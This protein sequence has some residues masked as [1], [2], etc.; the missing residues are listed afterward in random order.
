MNSNKR[1]G[2][3]FK[4]DKLTKGE[5]SCFPISV[6]QQLNREEVYERITREDLRHLARTMDHHMLRLNV[7]DF[8]CRLNWNHEKVLELKEIFN[9]DQAAKAE[10]GEQ[11]ETWEVYWQKM[12]KHTEWADG[13]FIRATAWYLQMV[14]QIMDTKCK[15]DEP[16]YRIDGDFDDC[17]TD[18]L[19]IGYVSEVH[20]QS[21]LLDD[22]SDED[23]DIEESGRVVDDDV[24]NGQ[25]ISLE[26]D[27][28][29]DRL[30]TDGAVIDDESSDLPSLEYQEEEKNDV[31]DS[32]SSKQED[33]E[34]C[35]SCRKNF[36]HVLKHIKKSKK[37]KV[38]DADIRRLEERSKMIR[39]EKV[40]HW[41]SDSR[42]RLRDEDYQRETKKIRDSTAKSRQK[43]K[44]ADPEAYKA[45][46][47]KDNESKKL[48]QD[49]TEV[50]RLRR[51]QESVM[52]G[53]LFVCVSCHGK[54]FRCSVKILTNRLVQQ[55]DDRIPIQDCIDFD[56]V[57]KVVTESRHVSL[58]PMFK[59]S[60][61][62]V[63][64]R[65]ICETCLRYLKKGEL[66]PKS[67]KNS[68]ELHYT[69]AGL[70]KEDLCL[71]ELEGSLIAQNIVFQKIYQLPKSR[72]T[73]L[74]DKIVNV[75]ISPE[76]INNTLALLPRTPAQAGLIGIS[77]KRK[78]E[79]KNTHK[80]QLI[81]PDK[82]FRMLQKLKESGSPYHQNLLTPANYRLMC[83]ETDK[84]G[85]ET[86]Y[87]EE[88]DILEELEG[89]P[90]FDLEDEITDEETQE[91]EDS[92]DEESK[93]EK[94]K[95]LDEDEEMTKKDPVRKYHF[96]YDESLCMMDKFPEISVAPGEGQRPKG[97]LG[98]KHWDVKAF[99]HLHNLDGS[100]GKD[101]D[102]KVKL[103]EQDYFIQRI[104]N[105]EKRFAETPAYLYSSVAYLEE[106]RIQQSL[107]LVGS[108]G[109][110]VTGE[111]GSVSYQLEDE[112]RV[113]ETIPN[114][115]KYW[116]R[117]KYE[118]LAK[119]ENLG[120]FH[121]FFTLSCADK[122]WDATFATILSERGYEIMFI[123]T[124]V[125]GLPKTLVE[126]KTASGDWKPLRQFLD[127]DI[128]DSK[129]E[130]IRGNVV[131]A[132]RYFHHRVKSFISKIVM[133]KSNP[134]KVK[135][136]TYKVEFQERGNIS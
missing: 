54:M 99:P 45:Q 109:K 61:L 57:T 50:D 104:I 17:C 12:L 60:Q 26:E 100:N 107:S 127:E 59:N 30:V 7:K 92:D 14:I 136:Y 106:K 69:D 129:H 96:T 56:V 37:C 31:S 22:Y 64:E 36:K 35:P 46:I 79:M 32:T 6:V 83:N 42:K 4:L 44:E 19:Y 132:T 102:R 11:S 1:L 58:P 133:S 75:P 62:E 88:E 53:P 67:F 40:K 124:D 72:W 68:L 20:Y 51:F 120:P 135:N 125:D 91:H 95:S 74:K 49:K 98:D 103:R 39:K 113:L 111:G 86:I 90:R 52:Y 9:I 128:A 126:V 21:L 2:L 33:N 28:S 29:V 110:E 71:T 131:M 130:L 76:A 16:F 117:M 41:K 63:G 101:E 85:Y 84:T 121:F 24:K 97:I 65:F 122:R 18:I 119:I 123:K 81:N 5:G 77:L 66:P 25:N 89:M 15:E 27:S 47:K 73:G 80:Q 48:Q 13:Y 114:S 70:K 8:I 55:I 112:F 78:K 38:K 82:I 87:G 93:E 34:R 115:P 94:E 116:Q 43:C 10:V 134:M 3:D 23:T 105:K 118:I 108:R